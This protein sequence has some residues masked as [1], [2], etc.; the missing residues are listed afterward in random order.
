MTKKAFLELITQSD[1]EQFKT[2]VAAYQA[3]I[4]LVESAHLARKIYTRV[5][6]MRALVGF[7][8]NPTAWYK[9]NVLVINIREKMKLH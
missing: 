1:S 3:E 9:M 7:D 8:R 4:D 2:E 6:N 5:R